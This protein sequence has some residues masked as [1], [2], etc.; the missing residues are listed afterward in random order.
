MAQLTEQQKARRDEYNEARIRLE[1]AALRAE[2]QHERDQLIA[3]Y[4]RLGVDVARKNITSP[5]PHVT[6]QRQTQSLGGPNSGND[7]QE[8]TSYQ[9]GD[10][11]QGPLHPKNWKKLA[12]RRVPWPQDVNYDFALEELSQCL[13]FQIM[14]AQA[15]ARG[16]SLREMIAS[17]E[18]Q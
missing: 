18:V 4:G 7:D 15:S 3:E 5:T 6:P 17:G 1:V 11:L 2:R 8:Y 12:D 9:E 13:E 16:R 14:E 10:Y